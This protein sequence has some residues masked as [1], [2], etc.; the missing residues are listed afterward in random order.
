M[1]KLPYFS[2]IKYHDEVIIYTLVCF[3]VVGLFVGM[4][5]KHIATD[6]K[7]S[8]SDSAANKTIISLH[9]TT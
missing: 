9:A 6:M 3:P 7:W 8:R 2:P 1:I 5:L 4:Y